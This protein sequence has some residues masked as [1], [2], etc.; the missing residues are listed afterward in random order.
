MHSSQNEQDSRFYGKFA[1]V[2]VIEPS[3]QQE[4]YDM[5]FEAFE[6]SEKFKVPVLY[7]I[8]T[9]LAHSR[10]AVVR[11]ETRKQN[12]IKLP[13]DPRQ[14]ILLPAI[15]RKKYEILIGIYDAIAEDTSFTEGN[16]FF[17]GKDKSLGIITSGIAYNYKF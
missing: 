16:V 6:L 15:A 1:L 2:P 11:K 9:R 7:R 13:A 3:N 4:A 8:T 5:I 12:E 17:D 10:S 14:F